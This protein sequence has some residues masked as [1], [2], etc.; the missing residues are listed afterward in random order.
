MNVY[1]QT[2]TAT[3]LLSLAGGEYR[4][5]GSEITKHVCKNVVF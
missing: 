1:R 4:A 5:V 2:K 3:E